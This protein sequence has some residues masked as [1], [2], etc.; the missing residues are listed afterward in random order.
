MVRNDILD[1]R[2][3]GGPNIKI[4]ADW[5]SLYWIIGSADFDQKFSDY[6]NFSLFR[7][8]RIVGQNF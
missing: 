7:L 1:P 2:E 4:S 5:I 8:H 3:E 6:S